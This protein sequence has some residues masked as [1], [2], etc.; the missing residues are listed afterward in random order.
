MCAEDTPEVYKK[1]YK[2]PRVLSCEGRKAKEP[3][4]CEFVCFKIHTWLSGKRKTKLI[5]G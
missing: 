1:E 3:L 4:N 2:T 5:N